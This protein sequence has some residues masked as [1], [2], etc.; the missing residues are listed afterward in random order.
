MAEKDEQVNKDLKDLTDEERAAAWEAWIRSEVNAALDIYLPI[1]V[2]GNVNTHY[3]PHV[4]EELESGPVTDNSKAG[5]VLISLAFD[6]EKPIDLTK[7][8][9][10]DGEEE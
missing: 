1:S 6:F 5:G 4:I 3:Y 9:I 10:I 8:R 2:F 7:P